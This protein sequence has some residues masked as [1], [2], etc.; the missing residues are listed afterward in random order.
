MFAM[1]IGRFSGLGRSGDSIQPGTMPMS[2]SRPASSRGMGTSNVRTT[3]WPL[4]CQS[5][6]STLAFAPASM[7]SS[8]A[9]AP[10]TL[11]TSRAKVT[12]RRISTFSICANS[13]GL[14][15]I[16]PTARTARERMK[17]S[18]FGVPPMATPKS[19][20]SMVP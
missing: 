10:R 18:A 7:I 17:S 13:Q 2:T 5:F 14:F 8:T 9:R 12:L 20:I 15:R 3:S 6:T 16:C 1:S 19:S 4:N 11:S